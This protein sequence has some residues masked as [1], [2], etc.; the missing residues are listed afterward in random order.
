MGGE[1]LG[2]L[3]ALCPSVGEFQGQEVGED[4][5]VSRGRGWDECMGG[6]DFLR[7]NI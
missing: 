2:P 3:W 6:G 5:L 7:G 1:A 4:V